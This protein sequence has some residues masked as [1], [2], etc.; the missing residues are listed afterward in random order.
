MTDTRKWLIN[1]MYKV[2]L[3]DSGTRK[4]T[5]GLG[6]EEGWRSISILCLIFPHYTITSCSVQQIGTRCVGDLL[7]I[8]RYRLRACGLGEGSVQSAYFFLKTAMPWTAV[9]SPTLH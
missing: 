4:D 2:K 6:C 9:Q 8:E 3:Y 1:E 7:R 5:G